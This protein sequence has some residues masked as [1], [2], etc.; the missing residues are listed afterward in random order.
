MTHWSMRWKEREVERGWA[1]FEVGENA[2]AQNRAER[3]ALSVTRNC[4][5]VPFNRN[6][7][8]K[9]PRGTLTASFP[10][11]VELSTTFDDFIRFGLMMSWRIAKSTTLKGKS[12]LSHDVFSVVRRHQTT[13]LLCFFSCCFSSCCCCSPQSINH[14]R[15][16]E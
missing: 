12:L 9:Q 2:S 7:C 6:A 10:R 13:K 14:Q 8:T 11:D 15:N 5:M 1:D 4:R 16:H 3:R